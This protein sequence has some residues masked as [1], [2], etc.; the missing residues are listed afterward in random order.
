MIFN[1][2]TS[3]KSE[4][5]TTIQDQISRLMKTAELQIWKKDQVIF[6][7]D[8]KPLGL[9]LVESGQIAMEFPNQSKKK[10]ILISNKHCIL[11]L[12]FLL[13]DIPYPFS[14]RA[15]SPTQTW[16]ISRH[17]VVTICRDTSES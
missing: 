15:V 2:E 6:Y 4:I 17:Q 3:I 14:A 10:Q 12:D 11:G 7:A 8:H 13:A 1:T 9:Y 5:Y 16:F